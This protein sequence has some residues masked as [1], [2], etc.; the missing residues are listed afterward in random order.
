MRW[1]RLTEGGPPTNERDPL[2]TATKQRGGVT[3]AGFLPGQSGN[4][5]GRPKAVIAVRD[6]ARQHTAAA[7]ETLLTVMQGKKSPAHARVSAAVA[8]LD[9][10][11][12]RPAQAIAGPD[13]DP[14]QLE[15]VQREA[16]AFR[17]RILRLAAR[18]G[19]PEGPVEA[20]AV[21]ALRVGETR[22]TLPGPNAS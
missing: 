12:G 15:A 22:S 3:G 7:V 1:W 18:Y 6:L 17:E 20:P 19:A 4:R 21:G 2:R 9:R 13:G 10:G 14:L 5:G 16:E 8:I 11:W